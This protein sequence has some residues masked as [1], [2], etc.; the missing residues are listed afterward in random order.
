MVDGEPQTMLHTAENDKKYG[1]AKGVFNAIEGDEEKTKLF[2][3]SCDKLK[4]NTTPKRQEECQM[5]S[6]YF[7]VHE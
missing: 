2:L 4:Y 1:Y 5:A 7:L 3:T 6:G